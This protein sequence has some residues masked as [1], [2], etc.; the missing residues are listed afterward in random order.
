MLVR[1]LLILFGRVP[2]PGEVKTR[3]C[4]PLSPEEASG[5]YEA[6]LVDVCAGAL[7][8]Q[9]SLG[10]IPRLAIAGDPGPDLEEKMGVPLV[11]QRGEDLAGRMEDAFSQ[12]FSE[13][14][15]PIVL[16]NSDSPDLEDARVGEAF[17]LLEKDLADLV[18]GPDM[19][20]GYYLIGLRSPQAFLFRE[21]PLGDHAQGASVFR[22]TLD[23]A[24]SR[25]LRSSVLRAAPDVD[26]PGDLDS[27]KKRLAISPESAPNTASWL[28][29]GLQ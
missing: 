18:L 2:R 22:R 20:G 13:G 19:G 17:Q 16:R 14:F 5:L 10:C 21:L 26:L 8:I 1:P 6:F 23:L 29:G 12:G 15:G 28:D 24:L 4:P 25:G 9:N 27:L 7:R 3:L 11:P